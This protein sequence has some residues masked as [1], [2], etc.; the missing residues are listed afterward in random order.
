M[1]KKL[2]EKVIDSH[3]SQKFQQITQSVSD[4]FQNF[5]RDENF[6]SLTEDDNAIS[7]PTTTSMEP[8]FSNISLTSTPNENMNRYRKTSTSSVASDT[9]FLPRY[10]SVSSIYHLQSD[11]DISA[12]EMEDNASTSSSQLGHLSKEQIYAAFQKSQMRYHKY[13]GRFTDLANHYK[14]LEREFLKLKTEL[15]KTQERSFRR[16]KE[17]KEQCE[18]EQKAKA[19]LESSLRVDLDEK[20]IQINTLKDK[21]TLLQN[22]SNLNLDFEQ[23]TKNLNEVKQENENLNSVN[24]EIKAKLIV[25]QS[26]EDEY[27]EKIKNCKKILQLSKKM[28]GK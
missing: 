9:S 7:S 18:L 20:Q 1:F 3:T 26:K 24:Q 21:I 23:L 17:L 6:F 11:L 13:R 15:E 2:K 22:G 25:L 14:K 5:D 19:H 28:N 16:V 10:D 27:K 12:S 8:G 4:K